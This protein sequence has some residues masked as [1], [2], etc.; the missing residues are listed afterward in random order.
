MKRKATLGFLIRS[1][2]ILL[3]FLSPRLLSAQEDGTHVV[4]DS[5]Q[6]KPTGILLPSPIEFQPLESSLL[7]LLSPRDFLLEKPEEYLFR[8]PT[9]SKPF[10]N[11]V[12]KETLR[13]P[14]QINPSLL[15]K[16][17]YK[18]GGV[19]K[20]W[21][22]GVLFASGGQTSVPGIGRFN[23]ASL[24]YQHALNDRFSFQV[25]I[26]AMKINMILAKGQ[27][28]TTSGSL[29][30]RASDRIGFKVF[31]SYDMGNSFGMS[32]DRYGATM[33]IEMTDRF[34]MEMGVQRYYNSL[35]G[36]ET[37]PIV[38]P[39][40]K[41]NEKFKLGLD[42]GG[43]VYE[44]LNSTIFQQNRDSGPTIAPPRMHRP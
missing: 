21:N 43:I 35:R 40:Y 2:L 4:G 42:V 24:G 8:Q 17:D 25:G 18:T 38:I 15:F 36:W 28:F 13:V 20:Q 6:V 1:G 23:D 10:Y 27:V 16:G 5:L 9:I 7:D 19:L 31:G 34:G 22:N 32:T 41:F 26:D 37:V 3:L 44:I 14:Y 29:M 12:L 39:S 11:F 33:T 30:Y